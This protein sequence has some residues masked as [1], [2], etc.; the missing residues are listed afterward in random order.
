MSGH[1]DS[2]GN[3]SRSRLPGGGEAWTGAD[4]DHS[5]TPLRRWGPRPSAPK[6]T[7]CPR[8]C[9]LEPGLPQGVVHSA[10]G[11]VLSLRFFRGRGLSV[12]GTSL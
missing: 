9:S 11:P 4:G 8:C 7:L 3:Y 12:N 6:G 5:G 1:A 2:S 10:R